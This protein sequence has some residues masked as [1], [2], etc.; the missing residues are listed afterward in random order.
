MTIKRG[1]FRLYFENQKQI[2][3]FLDKEEKLKRKEHCDIFY[4]FRIYE[5]IMKEN[6]NVLDEETLENIYIYEWTC[7]DK[8]RAYLPYE[9]FHREEIKF[10]QNKF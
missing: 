7:L 8:F 2:N 1:C 10:K 9:I 6:G 3:K 5:E 4:W